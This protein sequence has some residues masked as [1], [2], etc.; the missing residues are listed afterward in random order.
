MIKKSLLIPAFALLLLAGCSDAPTSA[1]DGFENPITTSTPAPAV[2]RA[3]VSVSFS[4]SFGDD[5]FE[6]IN[7]AVVNESGRT[8]GSCEDG[9]FTNPAGQTTGGWNYEHCVIAGD[10]TYVMPAVEGKL[11]DNGQVLALTIGEAEVKYQK[12]NDKTLSGDVRYL[13][14]A[15]EENEVLWRMDLDQ[16]HNAT[17]G[18]GNRFDAEDLSATSLSTE[19][20]ACPTTA[21]YSTDGGETWSEPVCGTMTWIDEEVDE[22]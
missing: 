15:D 7:G 17:N 19:D 6:F 1:L 16:F 20:E 22:E 12:N 18:S 11:S 5:S 10:G 8:I 3:D 9:Y 14:V 13:E 4:H 2:E 21:E